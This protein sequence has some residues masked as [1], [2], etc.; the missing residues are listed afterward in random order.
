MRQN[1]Y[2]IRRKR[3]RTGNPHFIPFGVYMQRFASRAVK[4]CP[5]FKTCLQQCYTAACYTVCDVRHQCTAS[6]YPLWV[7]CCLEAPSPQAS[8]ADNPSG[9]DQKQPAAPADSKSK[10]YVL[11]LKSSV[12]LTTIYLPVFDLTWVGVS[13]S[14]HSG[15]R[16]V[17]FIQHRYDLHYNFERAAYG[18]SNLTP[19]DNFTT[20]LLLF[21]LQ[22][23]LQHSLMWARGL[24]GICLLYTSP[25]PR[26]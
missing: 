13:S 4:T 14:F 7:V 25:S 24:C 23:Y 12:K 19:S 2:K 6:V 5:Y 3:I 22:H 18:H 1:S 15:P 17:S 11:C 9:D 16:Y 20:Q 21:T 10:F 26:D 8:A